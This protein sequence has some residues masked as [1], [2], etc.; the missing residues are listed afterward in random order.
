MIPIDFTEIQS[1]EEFEL[2]CEDLLQEMG[3]SIEDKVA[4]GPDAGK[5]IIATQKIEDAAGIFEEHRYLAGCRK[6]NF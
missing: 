3:F 2:F 5:D 6:N 4:R 1:G